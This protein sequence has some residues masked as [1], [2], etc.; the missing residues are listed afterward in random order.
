MQDSVNMTR[1]CSGGTSAKLAIPHKRIKIVLATEDI[2]DANIL[3][4]RTFDLL[5]DLDSFMHRMATSLS[6]DKFN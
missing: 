6:S 3:A 1:T 5:I 2:G 4:A